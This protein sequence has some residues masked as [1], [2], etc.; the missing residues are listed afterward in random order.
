MTIAKLYLHKIIQD[1]QEFGSNDDHMISRVFFDLEINGNKTEGLYANIKQSVGSSFE[2]TRLE[3]SRPANYNG[4]FNHE[5]F[6]TI[7][8]RYYRSV[9]GSVVSGFRADKKIRMRNNTIT[10]PLVAEFEVQVT[11]GSW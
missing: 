10:S 11:G 8:D 1:S 6:C 4:T 7:V 3:V 9:V 5:A 2:S